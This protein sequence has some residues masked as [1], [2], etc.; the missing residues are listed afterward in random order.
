MTRLTE[1]EADDLAVKALM[2]MAVDEY[3]DDLYQQVRMLRAGADREY[4]NMLNQ[5]GSESQ[6]AA[7]HR[8][9]RDAYDSVLRMIY[10]RTND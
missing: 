7:E 8:H 9:F 10:E 3:K 1:A 5:D 6:F 4:R 2:A